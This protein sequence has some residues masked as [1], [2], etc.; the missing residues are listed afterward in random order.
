MLH[1]K[2]RGPQGVM[3]K[4]YVSQEGQHLCKKDYVFV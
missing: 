1:L 4:K 3:E 2:G